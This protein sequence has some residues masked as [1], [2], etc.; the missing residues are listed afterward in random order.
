MSSSTKR[1]RSVLLQSWV[2]PAEAV[3]VQHKAAATGVTVSELLRS[4]SM[5][6]RLSKTKIDHE[7]AHQL[8]A[9]MQDAKGGWGQCWSNINQVAKEKNMGRTPRLASLELELNELKERV[10]R[11]FSEFRTLL[12]QAV[13][14]ERKSKK[15]APKP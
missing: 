6:Y 11:D 9:A 12:M 14:E 2:T 15:P 3:V 13:G 10:E 7:A 1:R 4:T 5:G 8:M